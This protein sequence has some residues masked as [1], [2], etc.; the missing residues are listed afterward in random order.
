MQL[1]GV[2]MRLGRESAVLISAALVMPAG[3]AQAREALVLKPSSA[4]Q[5]DYGA[6]NCTLARSFGE[7]EDS[8]IF[9][10]SMYAPDDTPTIKVMR[11]ERLKRSE[12]YRVQFAPDTELT[13]IEHPFRAK[14][15]ELEGVI[16]SLSLRPYADVEKLKA[17]TQK[18]QGNY[19][20]VPDWEEAERDERERAI[21]EFRIEAAFQD[22]LHLQFGSLRQ[23]MISMRTCL[24]ELI[25]HWGIDAAVQ[26][27]LSRK[28]QPKTYP[29]DWVVPKDYPVGMLRSGYSGIV[30]FRLIVDAEGNSTKCIIQEASNPNDFAAASC[31]V[32]MRRAKF[33]PALDAAGNPVTSYWSNSVRFV[34]P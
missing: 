1:L 21:T 34:I 30:H 25:G 13:E 27:S 28:P 6:D 10:L 3:P 32:L 7:G 12:K 20:D 15:G 5:M 14:F 26:R 29:G 31:N 4:W 33:L 18:D 16:L 19:F 2:Q 24:D 8:T 22:D 11:D 17:Q 9:A 23:P